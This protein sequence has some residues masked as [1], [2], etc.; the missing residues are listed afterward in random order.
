MSRGECKDNGTVLEISESEAR[1]GP[2]P[3]RVSRNPVTRPYGSRRCVTGPGYFEH[4]ARK[5]ALAYHGYR[6]KR[7][8]FDHVRGGERCRSRR[9]NVWSL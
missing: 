3:W 1:D 5:R 7:V 9:T 6:T 2:E 4:L 8:P